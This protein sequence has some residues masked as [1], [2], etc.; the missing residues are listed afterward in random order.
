MCVV[1][2]TAIVGVCLCR[3]EKLLV[4][5]GRTMAVHHRRWGLSQN[6]LLL[7]VFAFGGDDEERI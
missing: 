7:F 6:M 4:I 2:I 1:V 3:M 5:W